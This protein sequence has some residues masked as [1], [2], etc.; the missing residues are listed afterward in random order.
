M[1]T[2]LVILLG[3]GLLIG[4]HEAAHMIVAKLFGVKV[5]KFAIGFG[6]ILFSKQIGETSYELRILPLGG[7]VQFYGEKP[8]V[9]VERGFFSLAWYKRVLIA[10]AGPVMNLILGFLF[11][12]GLLVFTKGWPIKEGIVKA[13]ELCSYVI[14]QTLGWVGGACLAKVKTADLAGPVMV[15]KIMADALKM[16]MSQFVFVLSIISLSL[17][18]FNILPI[19]GLD[20]GHIAL[21]TIV[22][23]VLRKPLSEKVYLIWSYLG[24]VLLMTLMIYMV[25]SDVIKLLEK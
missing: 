9:K 14:T 16:G 6:P 23:G 24:F 4:L 3:L 25:F 21:Y 12:L 2:T 20:G 5:I 18:L 17:G 7:F 1:V 22:E 10:L 11:I 13:F 8:S 19:P 15:T